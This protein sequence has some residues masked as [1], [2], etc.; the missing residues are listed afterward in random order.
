MSCHIYDSTALHTGGPAAE[1]LP[2]S[3]LLCVHV[4]IHTLSYADWSWGQ[5]KKLNIGR[6]ILWRLSSQQLVHWHA[7]LNSIWRR[8]GNRCDLC[9]TRS[10][11]FESPSSSNLSITVFL[12]SWFTNRLLREFWH[13]YRLTMMC[14]SVC[15]NIAAASGSI[16][17]DWSSQQLDPSMFDDSVYANCACTYTCTHH[18]CLPVCWSEPLLDKYY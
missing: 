14:V 16:N 12:L 18:L 5:D 4:T 6:Q 15:G 17:S 2:S 11:T 3:K 1:K 7:I 13:P 8:M 9:N 10:N